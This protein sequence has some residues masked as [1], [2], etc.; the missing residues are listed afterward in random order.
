MP[1]MGSVQ[2]ALG[3]FMRVDLQGNVSNDSFKANKK[4]LQNSSKQRIRHGLQSDWEWKLGKQ[5]SID[6]K[7]A[8]TV[9]RHQIPLSH[10]NSMDVILSFRRSSLYFVMKNFL[11]IENSIVF[12]WDTRLTWWRRGIQNRMYWGTQLTVLPDSFKTARMWWYYYIV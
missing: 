4:E 8:G 6:W 1:I 9:G 10:D 2:K 3:S 12:E 5:E 7:T 11:A